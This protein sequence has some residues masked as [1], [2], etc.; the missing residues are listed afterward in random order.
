MFYSFQYAL[1][2]P[3]VRWVYRGYDDILIN[4]HLLLPYMVELSRKYDPLN[5]FIVRG[6]CVVNGPVYAQGGAGMV[7]SRRAVEVLSRKARHAIWDINGDFDDQRLGYVFENLK[8]NAG[9]CS[10]SAFLGF[11]FEKAEWQRVEKGDFDRLE[12][13]ERPKEWENG[14]RRFLLSAR[15]IVFF[16]AG[17]DWKMTQIDFKTR[18]TMA[19][20]LW[21]APPD[22]AVRRY[23]NFSVSLCHWSNATRENKLFNYP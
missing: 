14:C 23:K 18:T 11:S 1:S 10:S 12:E 9:E 5:E 2:D 8:W 16:H 7:L 20:N 4:F 22:V 21:K 19:R 6:D 13:C 15:Q 17:M 3:S